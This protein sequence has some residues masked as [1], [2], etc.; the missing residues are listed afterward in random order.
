MFDLVFLIILPPPPPPAPSKISGWPVPWQKCEQQETPFGMNHDH[1]RWFTHERFF[2][3]SHFITWDL[4]GVSFSSCSLILNIFGPGWTGWKTH[5]LFDQK[6]INCKVHIYYQNVFCQIKTQTWCFQIYLRCFEAGICDERLPEV[7]RQQN[8]WSLLYPRMII[9]R[10]WKNLLFPLCSRCF[11]SAWVL[12]LRKNAGW[13][14]VEKVPFLWSTSYPAKFGAF[15]GD[16]ELVPSSIGPFLVFFWPSIRRY[17]IEYLAIYAALATKYFFHTRTH[18]RTLGYQNALPNDDQNPKN[19][20]LFL[21][22]TIRPSGQPPG[23]VQGF[24]PGDW[25]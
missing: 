10:S 1:Q 12:D 23:K 9:A 3:R 14:T 21:F 25:G 13:F 5:H 17:R 20:V 2:Q 18:T 8:R 7:P 4:I 15:N 19:L 6:R 22:A 24:G 16:L 11:V